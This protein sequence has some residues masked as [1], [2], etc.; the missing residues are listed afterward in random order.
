[1]KTKDPQ[2][3]VLLK[4]LEGQEVNDVEEFILEFDIKSGRCNVTPSVIYNVYVNWSTS[5]L[6]P[7]AFHL[8][9]KRSFKQHRNRYARYYKLDGSPFGIKH[10]GWKKT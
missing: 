4:I 3:E 1:M 9:F 8:R 10:R 7:R 2:A 6:S 5:P